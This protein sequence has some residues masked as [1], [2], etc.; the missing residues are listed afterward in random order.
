MRI[1]PSGAVAFSRAR[2]V[3]RRVVMT[4]VVV[5]AGVRVPFPGGGIIHG[6]TQF[7]AAQKAPLAPAPRA[8]LESPVIAAANDVV[9]RGIFQRP[10]LAPGT[11]LGNTAR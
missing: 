8:H 1:V 2:I 5:F 7:L 4:C 9:A 11:L 10:P 6:R 3:G